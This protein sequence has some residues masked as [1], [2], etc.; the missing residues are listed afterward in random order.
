MYYVYVIESESTG[1]L[2]KGMTTDVEQRLREHNHGQVD[3]TKPYMPY[4]LIYFEGF[5]NKSDALRQEKY[6]KSGSGRELLKQKLS[7]YFTGN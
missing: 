7:G 2:Y 4:S 1:R 6:L 5:V 3:A